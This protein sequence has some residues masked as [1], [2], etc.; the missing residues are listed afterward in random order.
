MFNLSG[1][2]RI[3]RQGLQGLVWPWK[4]VMNV[5]DAPVVVLLYHRVN[6][7][8]LDLELLAVGGENFKDQMKY[9]RDHY[10]VLRFEEDWGCVEGG[11]IV[12]TF[13]DGYAD[14]YWKAFPVLEGLGV[15]ATFFINSGY[16]GRQE[17]YWWDRLG[18]LIFRGGMGVNDWER[19]REYGRFHGLMKG[20][21][22]AGQEV[23][24]RDLE[25][26]YKG[27][28]SASDEEFERDRP[29]RV[30]ELIELSKN[31]LVTIGAHTRNHIQLRILRGLDLREE[32]IGSKKELEG[33]INGSVEVFSY[34]YG[35][36]KDYSKESIRICREIGFKKVASNFAGQVHSWTN[37]YEIPRCL[38]RNWGWRRFSKE[39]SEFFASI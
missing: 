38:V 24:F 7:L 1:L 15:P 32:I 5:V 16:V 2:G 10:R 13:D 39:V 30:G 26:E 9:I 22:W 18:S 8:E 20:L 3:Y 33:W 25:G 6:E 4:K 21:D 23:L 37:R 12:V 29:M 34:P 31:D 19:R 28:Y 27:G 36:R 35:G 17:L 11:G 14:N